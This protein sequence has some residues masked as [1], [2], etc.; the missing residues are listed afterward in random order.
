LK[1]RIVLFISLAALLSLSACPFW[2]ADAPPAAASVQTIETRAQHSFPRVGKY[3][4]LSCDFHMHTT[5]SDGKLA[6]RD[7][8]LEAYRYGYDVIAITDHGKYAA[9]PEVKSLVDSLGMVLIRGLETGVAKQE[10]FVVLGCSEEYQPRDPHKWAEKPGEATVYYQ[11]EMRSIAESGGLIVHP[12]PHV[13]FREPL[14]WG[15]EQGIV[16]GIEVKNGTVGKG[17]GVVQSHGTYCYP[18]AFDWALEHNLAVFANSDL[19]GPRQPKDSP[20]TLVL[21]GKRTAKDVMAAIRARRTAAWFDGMI[22]GREAL[23]SDL[24]NAVVAVRRTSDA[25]NSY[26]RIENRG[27]VT[28]KAVLQGIGAPDQPVEIGP[29]QE[30]LVPWAAPATFTIRWDNL[31]KTSKDNLQTTYSFK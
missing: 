12:H 29:Y 6:P 4:V 30:V 27:P 23:L 16:Q 11:D 14:R 28:L 19:H 3:E 9:Y 10:H 13:G 1:I 25:G 24:I 26:V 18:F 17:W 5:H 15:I 20:V 2:A 8:V 21:A 31:W 22:W 7:R